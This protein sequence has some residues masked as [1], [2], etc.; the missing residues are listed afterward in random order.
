V[1]WERAASGNIGQARVRSPGA[2]GTF[3]DIHITSP[4]H[5]NYNDPS[6][7]TDGRGDFAVISAPYDGTTAKHAT[8]SVYD[9]APPT[10]A[11]AAATG[12]KLAGEAVTFAVAATDEFSAI[13]APAWTFGDGGTGSGASVQHL[14]TAPGTYT[15]RVTVTD[16]AGNASAKDVA[17]VVT[18]PVAVLTGATFSAK[19]KVSRVSGTLK[20]TGSAPRAGSYAVDV[21]KGTSRKLHAS[22]A[23]GAGPFAKSLKLPAKLLPGTYAVSLIPADGQVKGASRTATLK[24]PV[25]GVVDVAFISGARNGTAARTLTGVTRIWASFHFA[26]KP[27]GSVKL[28]WYRIGKK[29][30]RIGSTTKPVAAKIVSFLGVGGAFQGT[31]QAV[32]SRKGVVI[33]RASVKAKRG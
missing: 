20:V 33:A 10:V 17:V 21:L 30:V 15:A 27:K 19:W 32:L 28:T 12:S 18:S 1:A 2:G 14:Y 4:L 11:S 24:A 26:A 6:V 22:F 8:L 31:Y 5:A 3:G 16:A 25:S 29:R 23:L 13:G 7:A 9:A